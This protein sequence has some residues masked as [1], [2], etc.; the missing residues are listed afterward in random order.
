MAILHTAVYSVHDVHGRASLLDGALPRCVARWEVSLLFPRYTHPVSGAERLY[1]TPLLLF[2]AII[3]M[4]K[5]ILDSS[6]N[7]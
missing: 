6:L 5:L 7:F 3:Y 4:Y 1:R 2:A